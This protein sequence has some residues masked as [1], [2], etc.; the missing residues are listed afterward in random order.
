MTSKLLNVSLHVDEN[1]AF[2]VSRD[3]NIPKPGDGELLIKT[4]FSG[5]NPAEI[6]H[7]THLGIYPTRL[8]YDFFGKVL[9]APPGSASKVGQTV[10]GYTPTSVGR[11]AGYGTY[12]SYL[13]RPENMV[14]S[15]PKNLPSD[16]TAYLT[17]V[18]INTADTLYKFYKFPLPS[19]LT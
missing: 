18:T 10:A 4:R 12:Q 8:G 13:V 7:A 16:Y 17:V 2:G 19:D 6:K 11:P 1:M 5:A 9:K 3:D 14:Y 15:V